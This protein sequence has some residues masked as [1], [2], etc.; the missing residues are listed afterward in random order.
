MDFNNIKSILILKEDD[1]DDLFDIMNDHKIKISDIKNFDYL[2][3]NEFIYD[4]A[5]YLIEELNYY[6]MEEVD[7]YLSDYDI[8]MF[9]SDCEIDR[10]KKTDINYIGLKQKSY[11]LEVE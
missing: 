1:L 9:F 6:D 7:K 11:K 4:M 10:F 3:T 2:F 8:L 5:R